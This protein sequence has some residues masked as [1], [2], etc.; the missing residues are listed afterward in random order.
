MKQIDFHIVFQD[1]NDF[2]SHDSLVSYPRKCWCRLEYPS[3]PTL[4]IGQPLPWPQPAPWWRGQKGNPRPMGHP[5]G[6]LKG[7]PMGSFPCRPW[8]RQGS[9]SAVLVSWIR[10]LPPLVPWEVRLAVREVACQTPG[11]RPQL[12]PGSDPEARRQGRHPVAATLL[13]PT[14]PIY[15]IWQRRNA[16]SLKMLFIASILKRTRNTNF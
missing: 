15:R 6:H 11:L 3:R 5:M 8:D 14:N 2:S 7:H 13:G 9:S 4:V 12:V 1:E 10:E 16:Q